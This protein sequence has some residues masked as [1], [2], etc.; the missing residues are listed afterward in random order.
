M[1][2]LS[3]ILSIEKILSNMCQKKKNVFKFLF[4]FYFNTCVRKL[5]LFFLNVRTKTITS[6]IFNI[7]FNFIKK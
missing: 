5:M 7:S 3:C 4:K 2:K 6:M 1:K